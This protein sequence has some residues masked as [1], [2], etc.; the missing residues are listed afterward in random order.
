MTEHDCEY[1][2]KPVKSHGPYRCITCD[3]EYVYENWG[4]EMYNE[5]PE[6]DYVRAKY[7]K[8]FES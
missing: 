8:W 2:K 1:I 6:K 4:L 3:K 7:P 5:L